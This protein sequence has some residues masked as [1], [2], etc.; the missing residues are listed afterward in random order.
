MLWYVNYKCASFWR[1][2]KKEEKKEG[3]EEAEEEEEGRG[4]WKRRGV[5]P[6][7]TN[8]GRWQAAEERPHLSPEALMPGL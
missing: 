3:E 5:T 6:V 4:C 2:K 1:R 8:V 7:K